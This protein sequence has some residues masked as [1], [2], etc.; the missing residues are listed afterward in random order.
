MTVIRTAVTQ[1]RSICAQLSRI[2]QYVSS[3]RQQ[4]ASRDALPVGPVADTVPTIATAV[5]RSTASQVF[6]RT[7]NQSSVLSASL[8]EALRRNPATV[9]GTASLWLSTI[10]AC[11]SWRGPHPVQQSP[12]CYPAHV[13]D[14]LPGRILVPS[15]MIRRPVLALSTEDACQRR[16][17]IHPRLT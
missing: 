4:G 5:I 9:I 12:S 13:Q 2:R 7:I 1:S 11:K 10:D 8:H 14:A 6:F 16:V 15:T 3:F 17:A